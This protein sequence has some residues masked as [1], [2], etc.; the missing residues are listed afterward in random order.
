MIASVPRSAR[1]SV[2][3]RSL[4]PLASA[5]AP[6]GAVIVTVVSSSSVSV[7]SMGAI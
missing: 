1:L 7:I 5:T 3:V 2:K 4:V 6:V